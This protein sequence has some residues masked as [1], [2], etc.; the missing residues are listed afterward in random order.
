[1]TLTIPK[2]CSMCSSKTGLV[3]TIG[4]TLLNPDG[5]VHTARTTV[6][7]YE[8]GGGTY[9]KNFT[10]P[11]DWIGSIK[12][13][14]GGGT[15]VYA[16]EEYNYYENNP[17]VDTIL[18]N[19]TAIDVLTE[20]GGSGDLTSIKT[21]VDAILSLKRESG[22]PTVTGAEITLYEDAAPTKNKMGVVVKIDMAALQAGDTFV[23]KEKY[24]DESGG[25]YQT[26]DSMTYTG[27]QTKPLRL[28]AM[29]PYRYGAAITI[30]KTGGTDRII[31][32]ESF[33]G[34]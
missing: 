12:W 21:Q 7:I 27:A 8:I 33:V 3:D 30:Q 26:V 13:D 18:T 15:P 5:T 31:E 11:D 9:G 1:M 4:V 28:I 23:L 14:T 17:K 10:F 29:S 16:T 34:E 6:G 24:K 22:T 2:I 25:S 20:A 32:W 19:V